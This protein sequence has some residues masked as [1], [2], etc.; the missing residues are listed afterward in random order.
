[1]R[2]SSASDQVVLARQRL[3][4][5]IAVVVLLLVSW[6]LLLFMAGL[7]A[8]PLFASLAWAISRVTVAFFSGKGDQASLGQQGKGATH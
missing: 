6:L 3:V 4:A 8:V 5:L 7:F 1:M 2:N